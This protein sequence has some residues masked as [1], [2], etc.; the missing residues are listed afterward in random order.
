ML[1][2]LIFSLVNTSN[3]WALLQQTRVADLVRISKKAC[4]SIL[5]ANGMPSIERQF[6][7][8]QI[9]QQGVD[10][11]NTICSNFWH[12]HELV[13]PSWVGSLFYL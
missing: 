3:I 12:H 5:F 10:D 2:I 6:C 1:T 13:E 9:F 7:W 8:K 4:L 11:V